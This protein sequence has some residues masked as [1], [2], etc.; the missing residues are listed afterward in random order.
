MED[1]TR[2]LLEE[3][4]IYIIKEREFKNS[5]QDIYKIGRTK[6]YKQ[7]FSQYP[8][9][10]EIIGVIQTNNTV[11]IERE[12][13]NVL[14]KHLCQRK[15]I[16][17][18][19]FEGNKELI[20][21][22]V[23]EI[24]KSFGNYVE[25]YKENHKKEIV[26]HYNQDQLQFR[27]NLFD[28][29]NFKMKPYRQIQEIEDKEVMTITKK[30]QDEES[31]DEKCSLYLILLKYNFNTSYRIDIIKEDKIDDLFNDYV[32][33]HTRKRFYNVKR[34]KYKLNVID[35]SDL[36]RNVFLENSDKSAL[37]TLK[38]KEINNI[39][40][41][42]DSCERKIYSIEE[43]NDI[44]EN[45]YPKYDQY[46]RIFNVNNQR[47]KKE[48]HIEK[49]KREKVR[50]L[51]N[52]IFVKWNGSGLIIQSARIMRNKERYYEYWFE[53]TICGYIQEEKHFV[54]VTLLSTLIKN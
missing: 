43:T 32:N 42:K 14:K 24:I 20:L 22:Y 41:L 26:G 12:I 54:L 45:I 35:K 34:E 53:K 2:E 1:K 5:N 44:I 29:K 6:N 8:K 15:D 47:L 51:L 17:Y 10:S 9:N 40:G 3:E 36:M 18:E 28:D 11:K 13:I 31:I 16:G 23:K 39:L 19:Y 48:I 50:Y 7:R 46:C 21:K 37:R 27:D 49:E 38:I 33:P 52:Q 4:F 30:L 25:I